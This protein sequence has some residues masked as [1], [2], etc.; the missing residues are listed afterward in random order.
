M[1][2]TNARKHQIPAD[3]DTSVTPETIFE[4][5]GNSIRDVVPV[6]NTTDRDLLVTALTEAG[7]GPATGRPL[8]VHRADARGLHRIEYTT[9]N[10]WVSAS[11]VLQFASESDA[12]SWATGNGAL[13]TVGDR[14]QIGANEYKWSGS[15]W[16]KQPRAETSGYFETDTGLSG[17]VAVIAHGLGAQPTSIILTDT[18]YGLGVATRQLKENGRGPTQF[19]AIYYNGGAPF[20]GNPVAFHWRA[21]LM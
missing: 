8:V 3:G 20:A 17:G 6:A 21:V 5:F 16:F 15:A 13:L 7:E 4:S 9:G 1:P 2:T 18:T 14:C 19:Q 10:V 12:A 11:G